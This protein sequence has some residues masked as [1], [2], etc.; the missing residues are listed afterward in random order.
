MHGITDLEATRAALR[1][2][3]RI[4]R[5][6]PQTL[7]AMTQESSQTDR[8]E[9]RHRPGQLA[10]TLQH[11]GQVREGFIL[12]QRTSP[13]FSLAELRKLVEHILLDWDWLRPLNLALVPSGQIETVDQQLVVYNHALVALASLPHLPAEAITFPQKRPTYADLTA[14]SVPGELLERIEE[15][16]R[17]IYQAEVMPTKKPAYGPFRRTYAFFEASTWLVNRYLENLLDA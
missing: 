7:A 3:A 8:L 1:D 17:V 14:P 4:V 10:D 9:S 5:V 6:T 2:L 12:S 13:Q 16:E 11:L 15:L